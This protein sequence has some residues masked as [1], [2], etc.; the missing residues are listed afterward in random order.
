[1]GAKLE[2]AAATSAATSRVQTTAVVSVVAIAVKW[3]DK[4]ALKQQPCQRHCSTGTSRD[5]SRRPLHGVVH[6][7]RSRLLHQQAPTAQTVAASR[8]KLIYY[9]W[10]NSSIAPAKAAPVACSPGHV[11]LEQQT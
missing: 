8:G 9:R 11:G 5:G 1:M 7:N 10:H 3:A 4:W 6:A 2:G